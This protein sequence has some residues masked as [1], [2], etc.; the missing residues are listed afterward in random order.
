MISAFFPQRHLREHERHE[1]SID[2]HIAINYTVKKV[3]GFAMHKVLLVED[4]QI[5]TNYLSKQILSYYPDWI[6][7]EAHSYSKAL[8]MANENDYD[9]LILDYELNRDNTNENGLQL[10]LTLKNNSKYRNTP[11]VFET[12][13][14]EHIFE[15]VNKLNCIYYLIKPYTDNDIK[16][17]LDKITSS[18]IV[19]KRFSF[20]DNN[21]VN[22]Y[23]NDDDIIYV[24][25]DRHSIIVITETCNFTAIN[26]TLSD[27]C[28]ESDKL[29]QCHKS[30]A[31]NPEYIKSFDRTT[32]YISL[33]A[34]NKPNYYLI[35]VGRKYKSDI[36]RIINYE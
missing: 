32:N 36:T 10:G 5:I 28:T 12:S 14:L 3:K 2:Y 16:V 1:S 4:N 15:A 7:H 9:L 21:R 18:T 33:Y 30:Y 35:P 22:T 34:I 8:L 20:Q 23:I 25:S 24:H 27:I 17:M 29:I 13:Y 31:V 6:I 26:Y 11:I 19:R